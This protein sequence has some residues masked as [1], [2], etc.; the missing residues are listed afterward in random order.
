MKQFIV[1]LLLLWVVKANA[2]FDDQP[3]GSIR[4]GAGY[5]HDFP[6]LNGYTVTGEYLQPLTDCLQGSLGIKYAS[7]IG[8]PR[9]QDVQ[10]FTKATSLDFNLFYLPVHTEAHTVRIGLGYSFSFYNIKRAYPLASTDGKIT[11]WPSQEQQ[12]RTSGINLVTEYEY[13]IPNSSLSVGV[14]GALYK[15]YER[16]YYIGPIVGFQL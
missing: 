2:Q 14:R 6:G 10:E 3:P 13:K 15:A 11:S 9:T 8:Y 12:G 1:L 16:T 4:I 7:M 5:T